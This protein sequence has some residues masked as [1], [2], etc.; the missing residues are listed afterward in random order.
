MKNESVFTLPLSIIFTIIALL[1]LLILA[2]FVLKFIANTYKT[3]VANGEISVLSTYALGA[4]QHL[5]VVNFRNTDYF[6]G[7]TGERIEV[8]DR[9]KAKEKTPDSE[10]NEG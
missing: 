4:K 5:Y 6:L 8:L 1:F 2:W 10:L 7:V 9:C 3:R